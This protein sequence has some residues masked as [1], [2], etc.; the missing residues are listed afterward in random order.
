MGGTEETS[1]LLEENKKL[2]LQNNDMQ[3]FLLDYG[4]K[5]IGKDTKVD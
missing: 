5:W 1:N 3:K 2:K 4:I